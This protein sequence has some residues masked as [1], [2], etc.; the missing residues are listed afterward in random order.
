[1]SEFISSSGEAAFENLDEEIAKDLN[2]HIG[3][4]VKLIRGPIVHA[5][6]AGRVRFTNIYEKTAPGQVWVM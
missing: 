1:M 5:G 2:K 4:R 3:D 6:P